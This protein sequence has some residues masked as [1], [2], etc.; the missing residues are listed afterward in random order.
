MVRLRTHRPWL[1]EGEA[2]EN[3]V[4][5]GMNKCAM[6]GRSNGSLFWF[7]VAYAL[8][9]LLFVT[10]CAPGGCGTKSEQPSESKELIKETNAYAKGFLFF[11]HGDARCVSLLNME[12]EEEKPWRILCRGRDEAFPKG[13]ISVPSN[14]R[15]VTLSTTHVSLFRAAGGLSNV[16][17]ASYADRILHPAGQAAIKSGDLKNVSGEKDLDTEK[18]L[19]LSPD[20]LISYPFGD[21]DYSHLR[22]VGI[23]VLP[24]S[25]YLEEHPLGRAEWM[26]VAGFLCGLEAEAEEAFRAIETEYLALRKLAAEKAEWTPVVYTGSRSEGRWYAPPANSFMG[27]FTR[28]AAARYLFEEVEQSGNLSLDFEAFLQAAM[29]AD[30]WGRVVFTPG[31]LSYEAV[32]EEDLR[33]ERLPVFE[34]RQIFYC[35]AAETDYFGEAIVEPQHILADLIAILHPQTLP[36]HQAHYFQLIAP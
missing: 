33:Y 1:L 14:P 24:F 10:G 18:V 20:F 11:S 28:D 13:A 15:V 25:E 2:T 29:D 9:P 26:R 19:A 5:R 30:F 36:D 32:S 31:P 22:E 34:H 35:N 12:E 16:V 8:A 4:L 6:Q 7:F 23:A 21:A 3:H 27:Q 17:G